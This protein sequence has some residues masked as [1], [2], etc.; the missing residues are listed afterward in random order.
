MADSSTPEM[1]D[2]Q[3]DPVIR[4]LLRL[5][6]R[7][8]EEA[9]NP[10]EDLLFLSSGSV[11]LQHEVVDG[12]DTARDQSLP[13]LTGPLDAESLAFFDDHIT[14]AAEL[15]LSAS[16]E[17][18]DQQPPE[19]LPESQVLSNEIKETTYELHQS[20]EPKVMSSGKAL[21]QVVSDPVGAPEDTPTKVSPED[22]PIQ[23]QPSSVSAISAE[24]LPVPQA[25]HP[26]SPLK[27]APPQTSQRASTIKPIVST[28]TDVAKRSAPLGRGTGSGVTG[29]VTNAETT[30]HASLRQR[31]PM[32]PTPSHSKP[33][34][35]PVSLR[36]QTVPQTGVDK[37]PLRKI[38]PST[39]S[40]QPNLILQPSE[41]VASPHT[42]LQ[43]S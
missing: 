13:A 34:I 19:M 43:V 40:A 22:L 21:T 36:A 25:L 10:V 20:G 37:F 41:N 12:V 39:Q 9:A 30:S 16:K 1:T 29:R 3:L 11:D 18:L 4:A 31:T 32:L 2:E 15:D 23:A 38:A 26:L 27:P 28:L 8:N 24:S 17:K 5:A 42:S 14:P 7:P 33:Q 6:G 35:S